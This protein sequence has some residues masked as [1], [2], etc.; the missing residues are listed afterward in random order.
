M[1]WRANGGSKN[2]L[3]V[4]TVAG[5]TYER[6]SPCRQIIPMALEHHAIYSPARALVGRL[7]TGK[8]IA[9]SFQQFKGF[10]L[11]VVL[12]AQGQS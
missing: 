3:V 7:C 9:G 12:F 1:P 4:S 5:L 2:G 10:A 11:L 6:T 8:V